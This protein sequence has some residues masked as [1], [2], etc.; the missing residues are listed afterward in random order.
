MTVN[1]QITNGRPSRSRRSRQ[2]VQRR[3]AGDARPGEQ[4]RQEEEHRHEEAVGGEHDHVEAD[5][6][7]RI[8]VTEIGIGD[9]GVV[10]QHHQ[11]QEGAGAIERRLRAL[12]SAPT[13]RARG[14]ESCAPRQLSRDVAAGNG[15]ARSNPIARPVAQPCDQARSQSSMLQRWRIAELSKARQSIVAAATS[16][17]RPLSDDTRSAGS[18][19]GAALLAFTTSVRYPPSSFGVVSTRL[20]AG[21]NHALSSGRLRKRPGM[22]YALTPLPRS[23]PCPDRTPD[24]RRSRPSPGTASH[25]SRSSF[26]AS[27]RWP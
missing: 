9:D 10:Q 17:H 3:L 14:D 7:L 25:R 11:R 19:P 5:P 26:P 23:S 24:G 12:P 20:D 21:A 22:I 1:A 27:C 13:S 2:I 18:R 4:S 16:R 6:G 15:S 8:G